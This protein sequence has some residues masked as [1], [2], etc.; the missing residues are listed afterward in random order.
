MCYVPIRLASVNPARRHHYL[1]QFYLQPWVEG[2]KVWVYKR[3]VSGAVTEERVAPKATGFR[4][5]L[6]TKQRAGP[7]FRH[8]VDSIEKAFFS[9][10]DNDAARVHQK[11]IANVGLPLSNDERTIWALF[12][13]SLLERDPQTM[14]ERDARAAEIAEG[15]LAKL[16]DGRRAFVDRVLATV[17]P[18]GIAKNAIRDFMVAEICRKEVLD[19]F[20][21]WHW[22]MV[23][24]GP[25]YPLITADAPLVINGA[26]DQ[27][28]RPIQM[29]ALALSPHSMLV[30]RPM[31]W[32]VD[33]EFR[34]MLIRTHNLSLVG[35][36][37][38]YLYSRSPVE[39]R[40][41]VN[42][43]KA[44]FEYFRLGNGDDHEP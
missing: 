17:D 16:G 6:Y 40:P 23:L 20:K 26:A 33:D 9:V 36:S 39:D 34:E 37:S 38:T 8:S 42:L 2:G 7:M 31:T 22:E 5:D 24:L 11:L 3:E 15:V 4:W 19:H 32:T 10:L 12:L 13:N 27:R 44:L 1:P 18:V 29:A 30:M 14:A 25:D 41:P 43:R 21:G 28:A 35:S